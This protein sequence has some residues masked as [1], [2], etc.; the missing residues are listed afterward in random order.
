MYR[1]LDMLAALG[2]LLYPLLAISGILLV[3]VD[4]PPDFE[5]PP[6]D[7]ARY[8]ATHHAGAATAVGAALEFTGLL[9]LMLFGHRL[10]AW[11]DADWA[12]RATAA[13]A[14]LAVTVKIASFSPVIVAAWFAQGLT[15][16]TQAAL[17]R[18]NDGFVPVSEAAV[19]AFVLLAGYLVLASGRLPGWLGWYAVLSAIL[20]I[21]DL[22]AQT[23]IL[24][25]PALLWVS[26]TSVM[27][28]HATRGAPRS[29]QGRAQRAATQ[30]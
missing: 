28:P 26:I 25:L 22:F 17:F 6:A 5:A 18:L 23:A 29:P 27:L 8:V 15:A 20:A 10:A 14:G 16:D 12:S 4:L 19:F 2:G 24:E 9:M 21:A 7:I 11:L 3:S 30:S 1:K 13:L